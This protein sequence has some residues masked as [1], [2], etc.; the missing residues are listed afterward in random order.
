[1]KIKVVITCSMYIGLLALFVES[2]NAQPV[3]VDGY[4][5]IVNKRVI[6]VS[7]VLAGLQTLESQLRNRYRGEQL[8]EHLEIAYQRTLETLIERALILEEFEQMEGRIPE[9]LVDDQIRDI[10]SENFNHNRAAFIEALAEDGITLKEFREQMR[11]RLMVMFLQ[12]EAVLNYV[13]VSPGAV[14]QAYQARRDEFHTPEKIH[15]RL[16]AIQRGESEEPKDNKAYRKAE[17]ILEKLRAGHDFAELAR[18]LSDGAHAERGGD[19]GWVQPDILRP[20]LAERAA[21]LEPGHISDILETREAYYIMR[22]EDRQDKALKTFE[23]VQDMLYREL[24]TAEEERLYR[25]WIDRLKNKYS[26]QQLG[27]ARQEQP[28]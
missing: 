9:S 4:A 27:P 20:E 6:T 21:G 10:I 19:W 7:D 18:T 23:E 11:E 22:L 25:I 5:A 12:R 14:R 15:L 8:A 17:D 26:V 16:I 13:A 1:M 28:L 2:T 3:P 24:R